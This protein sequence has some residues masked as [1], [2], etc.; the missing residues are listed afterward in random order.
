MQKSGS[1]FIELMRDAMTA[2]QT[3]EVVSPA[4]LA[5]EYAAAEI[6]HARCAMRPELGSLLRVVVA[7][8]EHLEILEDRVHINLVG[9]S[10]PAAR[11]RL[12]DWCESK[13]GDAPRSVRSLPVERQGKHR[14]GALT[15]A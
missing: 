11:F 14:R 13:S 3:F 10:D 12:L 2:G 6:D 5:S 8:T 9:M 15:Q 1:D 4:F 7:P